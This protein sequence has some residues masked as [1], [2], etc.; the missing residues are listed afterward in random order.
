VSLRTLDRARLIETLVPLAALITLMTGA[1]LVAADRLNTALGTT[2]D[3]GAIRLV[4]VF[5][6]TATLGSVLA[7]R[8]S[9]PLLRRTSTPGGTRA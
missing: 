2:T 3:G 8:V 1:G 7:L 6:A 4:V 5:A 9:S